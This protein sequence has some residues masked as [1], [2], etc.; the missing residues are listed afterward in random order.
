[1]SRYGTD[2]IH[3]PANQPADRF[4]RG[5]SRISDFRS[6]PP[7]APFTPEDWVGST[8]SVRGHAPV[9][10]TR[11]PDGE[12]LADAVS[13]DPLGWLGAAHVERFG[14]DT[15]LLVKLL[16]AGQRLPIHAHP[17]GGFAAEHLAAAHGKAEAWYILSPGTVHLGLRESIDLA[18]LRGLVDGQQTERMLG[19]L[20]A[21]D[22]A[23]NDTVYVPPG[24]L[25]AIGPGILLAEVQEPEDLSIL[26][27]WTGF[28]L[29]GAADGH[30]GLGFELALSAVDTSGWS[31][32][33]ILSLVRQVDS[34]GPVLP[35]AS[36]G[37]FRLDRVSRPQTLPAGF[38]VLIALEGSMTLTTENGATLEL[39]R[40]TTTLVPFAAG[41]MSIDGEGVV[42]VARPP[43]AR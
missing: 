31:R 39:S 26:L 40:G 22:V 37:Y 17:D 42:I 4:Y 30:L 3:L 19:L 27:E 34:D 7:A 29:D 14:A 43:I 10:Q 5:G 8:T 9:G 28:E 11:L 33:A 20:H 21:I 12:L 18:E 25:H 35:A 24:L 15:M 2:P 13:S 36:A 6:G 1:M 41:A 23:P 38:A 32:D 16:D